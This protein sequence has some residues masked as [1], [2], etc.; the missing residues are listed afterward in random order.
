MRSCEQR[1][2]LVRRIH[3]THVPPYLQLMIHTNQVSFQDL[4]FTWNIITNLQ[5]FYLH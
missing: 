4:V 3:W 5:M 2:L 1:V